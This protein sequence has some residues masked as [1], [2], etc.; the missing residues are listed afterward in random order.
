M[1]KKGAILAGICFSA[2]P[3]LSVGSLV[4]MFGNS[5]NNN[6]FAAIV[7]LATFAFGLDMCFRGS[8][9]DEERDKKNEQ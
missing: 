7:A 2:I 6:G 5:A 1:K 4:L 9:S 8:G 3:A